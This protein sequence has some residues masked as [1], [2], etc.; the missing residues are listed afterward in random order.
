MHLWP[1]VFSVPQHFPFLSVFLVGH[2]F[3]ETIAYIHGFSMP[4]TMFSILYYLKK[5][6]LN[7]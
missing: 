6:M 5:R 3:Q 7:E 1:L 2:T 4:T